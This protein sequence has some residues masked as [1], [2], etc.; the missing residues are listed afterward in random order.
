M[1]FEIATVLFAVTL[2]FG[3]FVWQKFPAELMALSVV[4]F[5]MI[6]G[7]LTTNDMLSVF[8]NP[9]AMTVAAMFIL[10][11]S[12]EKTGVI[13][14]IG[15]GIIDLSN[16]NGKLAL[17]SI[18]FFVF[19]GSLFVNNTSIVLIMIPVLLTLAKHLKMTSSKLLIPLSYV[20]IFGG[21]CTLIGTSTNLLV[22][23]VTTG[24]G[25]EGFGMFE[26]F[27]PGMAMAAVGITYMMLIG[28]H[29]LPVRDILTDSFDTEDSRKYVSQICIKSGSKL[30]GKTIEETGFV[31]DRGFEVVQYIPAP[32]ENENNETIKRFDRIIMS[33]LFSKNMSSQKLHAIIDMKTV[34]KEGDRLTVL[35]AQR[36][37]VNIDKDVTTPQETEENNDI[38]TDEK[39]IMEG[40]IA[41]SSRFVGRKTG[42]INNGNMYGI[43]ILAIH[44]NNDKIENDFE[45]VVLETAD[46]ILIRGTEE[47]LVRVFENNEMVNLTKAKYEPYRRS[48]A[49]FALCALTV[50]IIAASANMMPIAGASFIAAIAVTLAGCIKIEEAY[51]AL[52]GNVLFLIY[53]MVAISVAM[54]NS[55]ALDYMVGGIMSVIQNLHPI[56]ILSAIYLFTSICTEFFSNNAAALMITP[57]AIGLALQMGIEPK[58]FATAVM[59]AASASFATPVGYQTNLLVFNAGGYKFNDFLK[60]GVPLNILMWLAATIIIPLY[61]GLL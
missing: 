9:A 33:K 26:I 5:L 36:E 12:L 15:K 37:I 46:A 61:W 51:E 27:I 17:F 45:N 32:K 54:Q 38:I 31:F 49:I 59:F 56:L 35:S 2:L 24:M 19:A 47:E 29:I 3:L 10:S 43:Q 48:H 58:A 23:G 13:D 1:T 11:A 53:A 30:I 28:R 22:D 7:S 44:R 50:T 25:V 16:F 4:A 52:K 21:T 40:I 41:P 18:F 60:I 14:L 39:I 42:E 34:L 55:G 8:A 20:S 6:T 57:I